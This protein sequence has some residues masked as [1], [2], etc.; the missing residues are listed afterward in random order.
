M[1][2]DEIA[3]QLRRPNGDLGRIVGEN[4]NVSNRLLTERAFAR[5]HVAPG[6]R[7]LE[8]G[9][10][11]GQLVPALFAAQPDFAY[12]G[13]DYS[14]LMVEEANRHLAGPQVQ[15][16]LGEAEAMP[17]PDAGFD[18][19]FT[20]NTLYFW[21]EPLRTLAEIGRVL[22]PG[23]GLV[24]A[25]RSAATMRALPF[26]QYGFRLYE[27]ADVVSLLTSA[28]YVADPPESWAESTTFQERVIP[29]QSVL[30]YARKA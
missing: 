11:N 13:L 1:T 5:L 12:V 3:A 25:I 21:E 14:A 20:A 19:V 4:M 18:H 28:G 24:I 6:D 7:V 26:T 22:R 2:L 29:L 17:F 15:F 9:P 27:A 30:V 23:G 16:V 10:G 8:I